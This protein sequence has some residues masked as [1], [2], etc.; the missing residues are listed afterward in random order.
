[1]KNVNM[2]V[3]DAR[4]ERD[5]LDKTPANELPGASTIGAM[6]ALKAYRMYRTFLTARI[7]NQS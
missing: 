1:M 7:N 3:E 4:A 2:T 5:R 6:K